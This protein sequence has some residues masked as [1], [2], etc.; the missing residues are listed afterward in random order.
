VEIKASHQMGI[1][2]QFYFLQM[3]MF[4][5]EDAVEEEFPPGT[6]QLFPL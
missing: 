2:F 3:N 5:I 6:N 1:Y 4:V